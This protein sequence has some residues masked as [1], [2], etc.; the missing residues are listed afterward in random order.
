LY[1]FRRGSDTN[2][3][4]DIYSD[5]YSHSDSDRNTVAH[6]DVRAA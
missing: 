3:D 2:G 1:H 6:T 5:V 4:T